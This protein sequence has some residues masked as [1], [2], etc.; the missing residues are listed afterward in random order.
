M[1]IRGS[2]HCNNIQILWKTVDLSLVPRECQCNDCLTNKMAYVSKAGTRVD[3]RIHKEVLYKAR[4]RG[5]KDDI[6]HSCASCGDLVLVTTEIEHEVYGAL[7]ARCLQNPSGFGA[8][9]KL[10][11]QNGSTISNNK[12]WYQNWCHP[13]LITIEGKP[14]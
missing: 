10:E 6:F 12:T 13:V 8:S 1:A 9:V 3:V 5:H 2:C 4:A 11:P 14:E 7:N